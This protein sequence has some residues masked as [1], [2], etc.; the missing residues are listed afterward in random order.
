M[1]VLEKNFE[2]CRKKI[3]N[4]TFLNRNMGYFK[5]RISEVYI[6]NSTYV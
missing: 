5:Y 4:V 2:Y 1:I 3:Y 6:Y